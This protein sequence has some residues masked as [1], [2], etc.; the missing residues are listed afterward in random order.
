MKSLEDVAAEVFGW[1]SLRAEQLEAMSAILDGSDVLAVMP[2]GSG[3]SAIYQVP[4]VLLSGPVLVIS[5]L[6]ALQFDQIAQLERTDAPQAVAI[7]SRQSA[8]KLNRA[9]D[10]VRGGQARYIFLGPEQLARDDVMDRL[11]EVQPALVVVDEA[12]CV[13]AWGHDF[14]PTYLRVRDAIDRLG[15]PP[16]AALTATASG[17]VRR[18]VIDILG[19]RKPVVIASGFDRPN[20]GLEVFSHTDDAQ[21]R[22]AVLDAVA[23]MAPPG[24][25]YCATR[26]DVEF[27]AEELRRRGVSA[28]GYHA[29]LRARERAEVQRRFHDDEVDVVAAT[30]AFGMGIDKPNVRFV[31][32]ASIPESVDTYYQQIGRAGRDDEPA[33]AVLHYRAEDLSLGTFFATHNADAE[34]LARVY[35]ALDGGGPKRLKDLRAA[36]G[37]G[38]RSVT[39]AVNLLERAGAVTSGRAGFSTTGL[40]PDEAVRKAVEMSEIS[41]RVDR[42]RVEMMRS[43]AETPDCQRQFL[44]AYFGDHLPRPCGNCDR[45]RDDSRPT[46][47]GTPAIAPGTPV[48]H[49]E[50][51]PGV[52]LDGDEDRLTALFDFYG[53]RVLSVDA[54]NETSV[55][56]ISSAEQ[57]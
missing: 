54:I 26:K 5:P 15:R 29:G 27:Y 55:L 19:L 56:E 33:S 46:S 31:V 1:R 38:G 7:N 41:E 6:I 22:Q 42:T 17:V 40:G 30:S 39:S 50:W 32:H 3:K 24:L 45:C 34:L 36:L 28:A 35:S 44:L 8:A 25:L 4:A 49:R 43:Y 10:A 9:W 57:T 2:T 14:R 23:E 18:E 21:K 16:V 12:H 11:A 20:I 51:G 48:E 13:S 47:S 53:Y 52:I 37:S